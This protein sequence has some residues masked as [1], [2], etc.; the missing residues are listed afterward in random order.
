MPG[1]L[2]QQANQGL[3][4]Q[5]LIVPDVFYQKKVGVRS[6]TLHSPMLCM[7]DLYFNFLHILVM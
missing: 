6:R 4:R 3:R 1:A 2:Q 5:V 7:G